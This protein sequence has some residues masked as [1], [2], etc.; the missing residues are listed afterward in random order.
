MPEAPFWLVLSLSAI[1]GLGLG[2]INAFFISRFKLPT[3]IVTLAT[4]SMF[5]GFLLF[6][7]GNK[8]IREIPPSM[9]AFA[10]SSLVEVPM[11]AG[12]SRLHPAIILTVLAAVL[13]WFVL[14]Y[15]ML[16]AWYLCVGRFAG[17][18]RTRW[19]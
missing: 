11:A 1:I 9:T 6:A 14:K 2:M 13:V 18:G 5:R 7:I 17:G 12:V 3:L 16:G 8:I 10:R 15:T 19:L 4:L